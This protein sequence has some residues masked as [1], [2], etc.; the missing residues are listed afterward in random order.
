LAS[1]GLDWLLLVLMLFWELLRLM[2]LPV[3]QGLMLIGWMFR[4]F[5]SCVA[6]DDRPNDGFDS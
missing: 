4:L 5:R 2:M 3:G 1:N 6:H